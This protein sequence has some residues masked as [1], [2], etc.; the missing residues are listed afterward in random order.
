M[1][2]FLSPPESKQENPIVSTALEVRLDRF[3][4][5]VPILKE[6]ASRT[7]P[8]R[9]RVSAWMLAEIQALLLPTGAALMALAAKAIYVLFTSPAASPGP[10]SLILCIGVLGA[11][12]LAIL[13]SEGGVNSVSA[14]MDGRLQGR[15]ILTTASICFLLILC[16]FYLLKV[17][18]HFSRAWFGLWY[19][20]S[21]CYL[22]G[23]RIAILRWA[24][25]LQA[26]R[27]L[28]QRVAV[29]GSADLAQ[30]VI[31]KLFP[32]DRNLVMAGFFSDYPLSPGDEKHRTGGMKELIAAAQQGEC[33]RVILALGSGA[34]DQIGDALSS[35][36]ALS[37]DV[38]LSPDAM[39]LPRRTGISH[40]RSEL[41]LIPLQKAPFGA[42]A[43]LAKTLMDY[44]LSAI[45][46][47][48]FAPVMLAIAVAIKLD[49]R[50]PVFFV[51][52][53]HGY[54]NRVIRIFKFRSMTVSEDGQEITQAVR[55]DTRVTRVGRFL[56]RTSL[57]ELPQ[58]M[59]VLRGEL[60]LV[61]PRPH[62]VSHNEMFSQLLPGY[63]SRHRVKPGITGLAQING[64]RGET[65]TPD[66]LRERVDYDLAYIN[67]WSL[68]LDLKILAKTTLIPFV[69][70]NAY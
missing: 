29:Y 66:A 12:L 63:A 17:S 60:S 67:K 43:V 2:D 37:I 44:G 48:C 53:R 35:L 62:A 68:W 16:I 32:S 23:V 41:V 51:Q 5:V 25:V 8:R 7:R 28:L 42:R 30:R 14:I 34:S 13:I 70:K 55:G 15:Q 36:E 47:I 50:G 58:L 45:A 20:F 10:D 27:R 6:M 64:F 22:L 56:R 59:N 1:S 4:C 52:S 9:P 46:L 54:N 11:A 38:D 65:K 49:S 39:M 21:I 40:E 26:D 57:D 18:S 19:L 33:D 31:D 61:G 69:G 24:R 3:G